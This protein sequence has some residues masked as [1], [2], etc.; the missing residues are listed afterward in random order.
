MDEDDRRAL[1]PLADVQA[2]G[3]R[4]LDVVGMRGVRAGG[5][6]GGVREA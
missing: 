5:D 1:A 4:D 3:R 2:D 6:H